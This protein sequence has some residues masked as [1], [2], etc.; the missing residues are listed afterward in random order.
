MT[1]ASTLGNVSTGDG[2]V[3]SLLSLFEHNCQ[4]AFFP[5]L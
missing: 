2:A 5:I 3:K 4:Y 1:K